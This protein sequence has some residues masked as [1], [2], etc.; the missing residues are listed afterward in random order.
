MTAPQLTIAV[1]ALNEANNLRALLPALGWADE[2][3]VADGGSRDETV[4]I[5]RSLGCR[6]S[7]RPFDNYAAQRNHVLQQATGRWVFMIDADERP[8][9]RLVRETRLAMLGAHAAY[10]VPIRSH[11]FGRAMRFAGTQDDCPIRLVRREAA[12]W[13]GAVHE[14][15][16]VDGRIGRLHAWLEHHTLPDGAAFLEK[17]H[18]YTRLEAAARIAR[19]QPPHSA[20]AW[21][22]PPREFLRRLIWK[23]GL[24]DG[25]QGWAFC[26]LSGLSAWALAREHARQWSMSAPHELPRLVPLGGTS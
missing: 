12:Q 26:A 7:V 5:A 17:M 4:E 22:A 21:I 14:I 11:I 20:E 1:I 16:H 10:R 9:A 15:C 6:V 3:L 18:R 25:P 13:R 2:V 24:L 8:T 23:L 19:R